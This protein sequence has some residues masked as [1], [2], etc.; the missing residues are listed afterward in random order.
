MSMEEL[1][2]LPVSVDLRTAARAFGIGRDAAY[3]MAAA[4]I[5]PCPV[6]REGQ[7]YRVT[8]P[9]LFRAV[10]LPPDAVAGGDAVADGRPA[11]CDRRCCPSGDV[12]GALYEAMLAAARVLAERSVASS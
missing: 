12:R 6:R 4:G 5:F 2:A 11:A 1:L 10:G 7:Q 9:D 3:R 8:R